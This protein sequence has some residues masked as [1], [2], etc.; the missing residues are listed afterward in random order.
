MYLVRSFYPGQSAYRVLQT[1]VSEHFYQH[2]GARPEPRPD[3]FWCLTR[4]DGQAPGYACIGL[5]WGDSGTLFSEHYVDR[6]IHKDHKVQR[7][8]LVE[9]GQFSSFG[10]RGAGRFLLGYTL[11]SLALHRYKC[12]LLTA[13]EQVRECLA[14]LDVDYDDLGEAFANRVR[15]KHVDWGTYYENRPRVITVNLRCGLLRMTQ[16]QWIPPLHGGHCFFNALPPQAAAADA[17]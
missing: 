1:S 12:V 15:D 8:E 13:T 3:Q 7:P 16:M 2:H 6:S 4:R 5:T 14:T 17:C 11:R 9:I 10:F